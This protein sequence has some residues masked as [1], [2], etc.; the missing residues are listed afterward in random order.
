MRTQ[1]GDFEPFHMQ[2]LQLDGDRVAHV[3]AFFDHEVFVRFGLPDRLPAD[4]R[5]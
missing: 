3:S 5:G 2:V 4:Y 1:E